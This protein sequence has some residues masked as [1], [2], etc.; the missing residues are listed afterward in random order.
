MSL[1]QD[2]ERLAAQEQRLQLDR[3]DNAAAWELGTKVKAIAEARGV[4]LA[5][6]VRLARETVF[7]CS[8]PGATP[9]N[10]DW[11]RRKRTAVELLHRSSYAIGRSLEKEGTTLEKKSGLPERDY[12][13]HGG[14][15]PIRVRGVGCIGTVTVSGVPQ[16]ED[17]AIVVEAL[18]SLAGVPLAGV[19]LD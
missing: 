12:A 13:T 6:E 4:T 18:A 15:F 2:I 1:D 17:H 10:A 11:V 9:S 3:F 19:A 14:C 5:I 8:M 16:R 7:F